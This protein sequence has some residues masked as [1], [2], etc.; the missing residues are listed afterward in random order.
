L[1]FH[2]GVLSSLQPVSERLIHHRTQRLAFTRLDGA[3]M[4][5]PRLG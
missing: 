2:L 5:N 1:L 4:L 3:Q